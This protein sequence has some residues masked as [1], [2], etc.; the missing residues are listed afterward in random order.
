MTSDH[1]TDAAPLVPP[2]S[3]RRG[4]WSLVRDILV[5]VVIAIVVSLVIAAL[6]FA[7]FVLVPSD[8]RRP[9]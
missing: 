7:L 4:F 9:W 5:I 1:P 2:V 8:R 6:Q 3:R